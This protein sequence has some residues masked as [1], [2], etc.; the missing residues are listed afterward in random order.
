MLV[1]FKEQKEKGGTQVI[2][3]EQHCRLV[4]GRGKGCLTALGD[5]NLR[6]NFV[7]FP[8]H[9]VSLPG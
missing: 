9:P 8:L 7:H 5:Q 4:V 1:S 3:V 2:R 6:T